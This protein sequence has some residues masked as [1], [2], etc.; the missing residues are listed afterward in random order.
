MRFGNIDDGADIAR[1]TR[2][3]AQRTSTILPPMRM[4]LPPLPKSSSVIDT[5]PTDAHRRRSVM[6]NLDSRPVN[7]PWDHIASLCRGLEEPVGNLDGTHGSA[8]GYFSVSLSKLAGELVP[9]P[10]PS[11]TWR[12]REQRFHDKKWQG[13]S[14]DIRLTA[15]CAASRALRRRGGNADAVRESDSGSSAASPRTTRCLRRRTGLNFFDSTANLGLDPTDPLIGEH[16]VT[17]SID[18]FAPASACARKGTATEGRTRHLPRP[19]VRRFGLRNV[20]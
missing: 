12:V 17:K 7:C 11:L 9:T 6:L 13:T 16:Q 18:S 10:H 4:A 5:S 3:P 8:I 14:T 1:N 2:A 19:R 15:P 20:T